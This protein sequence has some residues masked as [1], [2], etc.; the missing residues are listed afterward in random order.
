MI[1]KEKGNAV[2]VEDLRDF[3][4]D[5]IFDCGQCFRWERDEKG[6]YVGTAFGRHALMEYDGS[7]S[8]G[9][10]LWSGHQDTKPGKVGDPALIYHISEQQHTADQEVYR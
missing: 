6:R 5:N 3:D 2:I 10:R 7:H 8:A 9:H 1:V 4:L